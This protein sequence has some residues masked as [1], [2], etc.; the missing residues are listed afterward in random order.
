MI[1]IVEELLGASRM[2]ETWAGKVLARL[3]RFSVKMSSEAPMVVM[4][5]AYVFMVV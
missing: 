4:T 1:S 3:D 5:K 2:L